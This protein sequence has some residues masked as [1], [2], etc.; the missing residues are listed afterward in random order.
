MEGIVVMLTSDDPNPPHIG[1]LPV[2]NLISLYYVL[3]IILVRIDFSIIQSTATHYRQKNGLLDTVL[4]RPVRDRFFV[5]LPWFFAGKIGF[6]FDLWFA[7]RTRHL[8]KF[9][10]KRT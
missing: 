10:K 2:N 3:R 4:L 7:L 8:G 5:R 9:L 1:N 6:D